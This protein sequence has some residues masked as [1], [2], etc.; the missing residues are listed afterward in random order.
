MKQCNNFNHDAREREKSKH[1]KNMTKQ[2]KNSIKNMKQQQI[3]AAVQLMFFFLLSNKIKKCGSLQHLYN[4]I[5]YAFFEWE[6][7]KHS[8]KKRGKN[9]LNRMLLCQYTGIY[10]FLT[11]KKS[12]QKYQIAINFILNEKK[13]CS[14]LPTIFVTNSSS[15][16]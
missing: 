5:L 2:T 4:K 3:L 7:A 8:N 6:Q 15:T 13:T 11:I 9:C 14:P 10:I 1:R 16:R 12:R